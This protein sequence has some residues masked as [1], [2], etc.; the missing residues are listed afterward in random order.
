MFS[1][2]KNRC[3][4]YSNAYKNFLIL[5]LLLNEFF[6]SLFLL[7]IL[8]LVNY[9]IVSDNRNEEEEVD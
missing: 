2:L 5:I 8:N 6:K 1:L 3:Q 7:P 9:F 4:T